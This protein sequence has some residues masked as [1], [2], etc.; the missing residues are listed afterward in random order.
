MYAFTRESAHAI[1]RKWWYALMSRV[2]LWIDLY[3]TREDQVFIVDVVVINLTWEMVALSVIG[4]LKSVIAKLSAIVNICKYKRFHEE[5][6]FILMAREVH[7]TLGCDMDCF[8]MECV[9][10]FHNRRLGDH[11]SLFFYIQFFK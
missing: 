9:C 10:L 1:W 3:M 8:I 7:N 5:H 11:L 2:S 6:H 4:R